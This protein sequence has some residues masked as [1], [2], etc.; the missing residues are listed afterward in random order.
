MADMDVDAC[1]VSE[2]VESN[3]RFISPFDEPCGYYI[4][5][6]DRQIDEKTIDLYWEQLKYAEKHVDLLIRQ[7]FNPSFYKFYGVDQRKVES[8][9]DMCQRLIV[10]SFVLFLQENEITIG[11]C[12]SNSEFMFGHYVEYRWDCDWNL[13]YSCIC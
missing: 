2:I 11:S 10:E 8:P 9:D 13:I 7:G 12:L 3:H 4:V 5:G 6:A 1:K